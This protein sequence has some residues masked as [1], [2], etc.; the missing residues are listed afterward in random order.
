MNTS[1][2]WKTI[3]WADEELV[4]AFKSELKWEVLQHDP[5]I[6]A[7]EPTVPDPVAIARQK[8]V[9]AETWTGPPCTSLSY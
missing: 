1:R 8:M 4:A 6:P 7:F 5:T 2:M 9:A 3:K